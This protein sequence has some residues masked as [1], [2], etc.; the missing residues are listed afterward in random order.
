MDKKVSSKIVC[1][2][3]KRSE[4]F[5]VALHQLLL[6]LDLMREALLSWSGCAFCAFESNLGR[7]LLGLSRVGLVL[8]PLGGPSYDSMEYLDLLRIR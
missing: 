4:A 2:C 3:G 6:C 1:T 8:N 5:E 7:K